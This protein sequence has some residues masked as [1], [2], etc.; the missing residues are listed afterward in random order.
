MSLSAMNPI[1]RAKHLKAIL[2]LAGET[3]RD[4]AIV[5]DLYE[6]ELERLQD[7]AH[8]RDYLPLLASR[9][10]MEILRKASV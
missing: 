5:K 2:R 10:T 3:G 1:E 7:G 6:H 4:V 9:H 8:V